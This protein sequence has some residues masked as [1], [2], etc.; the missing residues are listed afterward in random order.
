MLT[1]NLVP[2]EDDAA[3]AKVFARVVGIEG[4]VD[5]RMRHGDVA[6]RLQRSHFA[7][8]RHQG[9]Q[10][11][12]GIRDQGDEPGESGSGRR[13]L[14]PVQEREG[15]E[16]L[17]AGSDVRRQGGGRVADAEH[18]PA[19]EKGAVGEMAQDFR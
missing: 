3:S 7:Q 18:V 12:R 9:C 8:K 4:V 11:I 17:S 15:G 13:H 19:H 16:V 2:D 1:P 10:G 6:G 5:V 14:L